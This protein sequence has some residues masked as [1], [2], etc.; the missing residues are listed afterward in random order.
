MSL[1]MWPMSS[2]GLFGTQVKS[3]VQR[4]EVLEGFLGLSMKLL[5]VFKV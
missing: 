3:L 4:K 2:I 1:S 5:T